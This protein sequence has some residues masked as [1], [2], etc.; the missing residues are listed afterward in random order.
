M[1]ESFLTVITVLSSPASG[2]ALMVLSIVSL[3]WPCWL[4]PRS[5][6]F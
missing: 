4:S 6:W 2:P 1:L 3:L 5:R